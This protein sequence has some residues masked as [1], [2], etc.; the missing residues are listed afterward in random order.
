MSG[1]KRNS[2][3][4]GGVFIERELLT[5][6]AFRSLSG[7]AHVVL[8]D[9]YC[10]RQMARVGVGK[11]RVWDI[12]NNGEITYTYKEAE[13]N[14][15]PRATFLRCLDQLV[16]RGLVDIAES[17][18]GVFRST[19]L[20]AIS[21]RW[22]KWGTDEFEEKSRRKGSRWNNRVGFQKGHPNYPKNDNP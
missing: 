12:T 9:F 5:S 3:R 13:R 21:S 14:G 20:Y 19:T 22:E 2:P 17:G 6:K 10:K 18:A 15:I 1:Q 4:P 11:H 7:T 16:D 8:L